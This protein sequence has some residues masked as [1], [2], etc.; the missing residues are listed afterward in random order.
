MKQD[1]KGILFNLNVDLGL[2]QGLGIL[3]D[4]MGKKHL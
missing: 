1:F 3:H 2:I 4:K